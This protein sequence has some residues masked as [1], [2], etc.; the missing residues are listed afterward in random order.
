MVQLVPKQR[1]HIESISAMD[2]K[3]GRVESYLRKARRAG[4]RLRFL[5]AT[6]RRWFV[7]DVEAGVFEYYKGKKRR[8]LRYCVNI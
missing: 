4:A 5:R 1:F 3:A 8:R 2:W 6:V 7:L